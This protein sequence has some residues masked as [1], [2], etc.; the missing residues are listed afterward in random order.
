[1]SRN[2]SRRIDEITRWAI[3]DGLCLRSQHGK[4]ESGKTARTNER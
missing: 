4:R 2:L 1:V 3:N